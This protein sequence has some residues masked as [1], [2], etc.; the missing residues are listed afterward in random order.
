MDLTAR[1]RARALALARQTHR[2]LAC[3]LACLL[4]VL[5]QGCA[6]Q[7]TATTGRQDVHSI[8]H[9]FILSFIH[10]RKSAQFVRSIYLIRMSHGCKRTNSNG[11]WRTVI[12]AARPGAGA[13]DEVFSAVGFWLPRP[14]SF[15]L[16]ARQRLVRLSCS[17]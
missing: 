3:L 14:A 12:Q 8:I 13:A 5:W 1:A 10:S 4:C 11:Q 16:L 9:S 15:V 6:L 2:F 17:H 7:A